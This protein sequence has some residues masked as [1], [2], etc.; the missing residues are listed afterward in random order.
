[1][2]W[3]ISRVLSW[4]VIHLGLQSLTGSSDLPGSNAS[5]ALTIKS[6]GTLFGL[7]SGRVYLATDYY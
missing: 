4:T 1:M 3:P 5:R 2:S 7:A 6:T